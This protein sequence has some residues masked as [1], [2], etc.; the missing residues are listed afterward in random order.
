MFVLSIRQCNIIKLYST[1]VKAR[2][3]TKEI[4]GIFKLY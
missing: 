3:V 2:V 4:A 1:I